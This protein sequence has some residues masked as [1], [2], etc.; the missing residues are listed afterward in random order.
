M[1]V[2]KT[3]NMTDIEL[4]ELAEDIRDGVVDC[5]KYNPVRGLLVDNDCALAVILACF[6]RMFG[7]PIKRN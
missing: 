3:T 1:M 2:N 5:V 6:Q 4:V 7:Q